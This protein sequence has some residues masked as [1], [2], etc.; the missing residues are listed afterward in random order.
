[1]CVSQLKIIRL[2]LINLFNTKYRYTSATLVLVEGYEL[3]C[4]HLT[5]AMNWRGFTSPPW[6]TDVDSPHPHYELMW[7]H[8]TPAMNWRGF[9]S[10]PWW[11]DVDS[12]RPRD[13]LMWIHLTPTMNWRGFTSPPSEPGTSTLNVLNHKYKYFPPRKYLSTSTFLFGEMYSSTFRVLSKCT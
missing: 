3:M 11:T 9:T 10:P 7:I 2:R 4:I 1:M 12:P 5:P 13:E 6:W 8:L